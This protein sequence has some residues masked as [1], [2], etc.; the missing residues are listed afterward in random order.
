MNRRLKRPPVNFG[1]VEFTPGAYIYADEDG[2]AVAD[3]EF[4]DI[5]FAV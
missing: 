1:G 5:S 2:I 4:E 3:K